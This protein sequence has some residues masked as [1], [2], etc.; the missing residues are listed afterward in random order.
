MTWRLSRFS[1]GDRVE[2]RSKE[3]ILA[4]LDER[5]CVEG[6][7]F[8]PE[9]LQFCGRRFRVSAVAHK[10][11]ETARQTYKGRR[12]TT[13]VH[14]AGLRCDGS[15]HGGCQAE[16]NLFWKDVWLKAATGT[17]KTPPPRP[18]SVPGAAAQ[19]CPEAQLLAQTRL[20]VTAADEQ[21]PY[22][23]QATMLYD[24][25][26]PLAWWD[27]RQYLYDATT[28]N[29]SAGRVLRA[30]WL[31]S[32]RWLQP[33]VPL[34]Y[35][36][37]NAFTD[38][39]YRSLAGRSIPFLQGRIERGRATPTGRLDLKPGEY[40]R[41]KSQAEIEQTLDGAGKNRGLY[42]DPE[43]MAPYC[44]RVFKVR[45]PVTKILDELTGKMVHM[46]QPCITL[47][48]VVCDSEYS[49]CRLN[50]PRA[51]P[52]YW[53]ELWL[54]RVDVP[55]PAMDTNHI[56]HRESPAAAAACAWNGPEGPRSTESLHT[57]SDRLCPSGSDIVNLESP[58]CIGAK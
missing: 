14:L 47:E 32:L 31:S 30:L 37:F 18:A 42:F 2:V 10:T 55:S 23:C 57:A 35:R 58:V 21:P 52:A 17:N 24:A 41:I 53:R 44:G 13:T 1:T 33:R 3:E 29:R 39:M 6:M 28:R 4:T 56:N 43:S 40:V 5:G 26:Q 9:M 50:C 38:R 25:T 34:G 36:L 7:P 15:A 51:I 27:P 8:M 20:P 48:G 49:T 46:K 19:V 12:L 11:C 16:C 45:R 22:A 54:E